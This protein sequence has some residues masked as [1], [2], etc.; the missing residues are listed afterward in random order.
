MGLDQ[1]AN[2]VTRRG[3]QLRAEMLKLKTNE[4]R[5]AFSKENNLPEEVQQIQYWRKHANLNEWMTQLA[6]ARGVVKD[7]IEF[8]CV[9][10]VLTPQDIDDLD[11]A[12]NSDDLP[13]GAGFFW[14]RSA[15]EDRLSDEEFI[16]KARRAFA[17][18]D[19]VIYSCWW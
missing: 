7:A 14:G 10:L 18:G 5:R 13:T 12:I 9:D 8:N 19:Q 1:Y 11:E 15:P 4:E 6:V 16:V 2:T 3:Q 17:R